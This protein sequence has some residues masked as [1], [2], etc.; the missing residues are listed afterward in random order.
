M[1][2]RRIP[3]TGDGKMVVVVVVMVNNALK[4]AKVVD[5]ARNGD[6]S[7]LIKAILVLGLLQE[8]D[9]QRMVDIN[10]RNHEPLLL[11]A[12]KNGQTS[13]GSLHLVPMVV[14]VREMNVEMEIQMEEVLMMLVTAAAA[15]EPH[16]KKLKA[17]ESAKEKRAKGGMRRLRG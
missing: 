8:L 17:K 15:A 6:G 12:N 4:G 14:K 3:K 10:N 5:R 1:R 7:F 11:L 16:R 2:M 13:L 9:K